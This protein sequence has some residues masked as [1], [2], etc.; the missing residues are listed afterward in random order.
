MGNKTT[1][2]EES[3]AMGRMV[4]ETSDTVASR[5]FFGFWATDSWR[6]SV[7]LYETRS[8]FLICADLSGMEKDDIQVQVEN[9]H[10]II[11]GKRNCPM[12]TGRER[13]VAVHLMEI[14][15]GVFSRT[16]EVPSNVDEK[17]IKAHYEAGMLWIT[18]PKKR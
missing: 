9:N 7:N 5:N 6:P 12:P 4:R 16:I 13:A 11:R 15:H 2:A 14:D 10:L 18:L 1:G 8:A 17:D 3:S